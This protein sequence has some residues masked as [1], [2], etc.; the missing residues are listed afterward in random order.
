MNHM[1]YSQITSL[2]KTYN[3]TEIQEHINSGL[4]WR[5]EGSFGRFAMDCLE[6]GVCMLPLK[7]KIDYYGQV[8]PSRNDLKSGTKGTFLN[9]ARFWERVMEGDYD[10][11]EWLEATF[12]C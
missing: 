3:V 8:V 7:R 10:S 1:T 4:C 6:A 5:M 2:Q 11:I 9:S 12:A